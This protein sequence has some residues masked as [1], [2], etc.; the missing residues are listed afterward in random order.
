VFLRA[1]RFLRDVKIVSATMDGPMRDLER[2]IDRLSTSMEAT[3]SA[4]PGLEASV[5]RL[6]RSVARLAVLRAALQDS[7][8]SFAWLTAVYPRK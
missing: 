3:E 8:D 1:R 5:T 6:K 2:S 7:V 4:A